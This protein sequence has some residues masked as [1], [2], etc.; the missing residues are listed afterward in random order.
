MCVTARPRYECKRCGKMPTAVVWKWNIRF[1]P[2]R[3]LVFPQPGSS[4]P[5]SSAS[6]ALSIGEAA[7]TKRSA[8]A[9]LRVA[10]GVELVDAG[11]SVLAADRALVQ[12]KR[13]RARTQR[14]VAG[15]DRVAERSD[16][17]AALGADRTTEVAVE[18]AIVARRPSAIRPRGDARRR[19]ERMEAEAL[20]SLREQPRPTY[21]GTPGGIG[22][23]IRARRRERRRQRARAPARRRSSRRRR[24]RARARRS[25]SAS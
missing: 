1:L 18:A 10:V 6:R 5:E 21:D 3:P 2:R 23:G 22:Y 4:R 19:G 13:H 12:P 7:S 11:D 25:R 14:D 16:R 24:R 15:G 9:A 8:V 20:R 17:G